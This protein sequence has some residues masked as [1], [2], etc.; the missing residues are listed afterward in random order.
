MSDSLDEGDSEVDYKTE[1]SSENGEWGVNLEYIAGIQAPRDCKHLS[2]L[3]EFPYIILLQMIYRRE[4]R[5]SRSRKKF[6]RT[7]RIFLLLRRPP[8]GSMTFFVRSGSLF[9]FAQKFLVTES[10]KNYAFGPRL[11]SR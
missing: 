6:T 5:N 2:Y 9:F 1:R 11:S 10:S 4:P 3:L 7:A 8:M